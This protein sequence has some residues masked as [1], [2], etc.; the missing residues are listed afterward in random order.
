VVKNEM[1][2]LHKLLRQTEISFIQCIKPNRRNSATIYD[3]Q[4]C[5]RQIQSAS[6]FD[7]CRMRK[8]GYPTRLGGDE[9]YRMFAELAEQAL[10]KSSGQ[11]SPEGPKS[12]EEC[13][14]LVQAL[15]DAKV[16]EEGD[17]AVGKD[18]VFLKH[19]VREK[20]NRDMRHKKLRAKGMDEHLST[21][22]KAAEARDAIALEQ[23]LNGKLLKHLE[24]EGDDEVAEARK[25]LVRLGTQ[26]VAAEELEAAI[27]AGELERLKTAV[28]AA[29]E[30]VAKDPALEWEA[31]FVAKE[32]LKSLEEEALKPRLTPEQQAHRDKEVARA[33]KLVEVLGGHVGLEEAIGN[34]QADQGSKTLWEQLEGL[35]VAADERVVQRDADFERA[36]KFVEEEETYFSSRPKLR[37][38]LEDAIAAGEWLQLKERLGEIE[39]GLAVDKQAVK[40]E[41]AKKVAADAAE[42]KKRASDALAAAAAAAEAEKAKANA[43]K[44]EAEEEKGDNL[45]AMKDGAPE[46]T[47]FVKV[48]DLTGMVGGPKGK[49]KTKGFQGRRRRTEM[50]NTMQQAQALLN[51]AGA[52]EQKQVG[53]HIHLAAFT[54][55][56]HDSLYRAR[57]HLLPTHLLPTHPLSPNQFN[58]DTPG[59]RNKPLPR[60]RTWPANLVLVAPLAAQGWASDLVSVP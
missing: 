31:L 59:A 39:A 8:L 30:E 20:L 33:R 41:K 4:L 36:R 35:I 34:W 19:R 55:S 3:A 27:E 11:S 14:T 2:K 13:E 5:Q 37:K 52:L 23:V 44:E 28:G 45:G 15:L 48:R 51:Q 18:K 6:F 21:M 26:Q 47:A 10:G 43:E 29:E 16:L 17:V 50:S 40:D 24:N 60:N 9:F 53:S 57:N 38:D 32:L 25:L 58:P 22:R 46:R 7:F 49:L 1:D 56:I 42:T 12:A 54:S